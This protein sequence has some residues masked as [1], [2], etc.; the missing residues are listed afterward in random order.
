MSNKVIAQ[1]SNNG[2]NTHNIDLFGDDDIN[3]DPFG[4]SSF[5]DSTA[6]YN[7]MQNN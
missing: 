1:I 5:E 7:L 3:A 4:T 6:A 2:N